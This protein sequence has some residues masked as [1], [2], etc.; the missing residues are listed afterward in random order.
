[1]VDGVLAKCGPSPDDLRCEVCGLH[2]THQTDL[3][4]F[5]RVSK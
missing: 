4:H 5:L 3:Y 1:M 2:R